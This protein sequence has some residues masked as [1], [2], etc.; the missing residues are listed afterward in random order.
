MKKLVLDFDETLVYSTLQSM[1]PECVPITVDDTTFYTMLRPGTKDFLE[2]VRRK[3][4]VIIWSTGQENYLN[5]V[6]KHINLDGFTLWGREHCKAMESNT[7]NAPEPYEK[8][9]RLLTEDLSQ[10]VI[11]DNTPSVFAKYPLNG[12]LCRTW[13]GEPYDTELEHLS[14]YLEWLNQQPSMQRDHHA[15]RLETLSLRSR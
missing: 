14:Y 5:A 8:P 3:F 1:G 6:W 11:V 2:F 10:I 13:R 4:D 9:L 15:W 12:I 7:A